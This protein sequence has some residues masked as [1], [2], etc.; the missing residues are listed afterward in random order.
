MVADVLLLV[1]HAQSSFSRAGRLAGHSDPPLSPAG[2]TEVAG[3]VRTDSFRQACA[4][5]SVVASSDLRRATD[6]AGPIAAALGRPVEIHVDLRERSFGAYDGQPAERARAEAADWPAVEQCC[7]ARPPGGESL[8]EVFRR[9][10]HGLAGVAGRTPTGTEALVVGHSMAWRLIAAAVSAEPVFPLTEPIRPTLT[11]W[12]IDVEA[13]LA[14]TRGTADPFHCS[15]AREGVNTVPCPLMT[16][17][18]DERSS[19]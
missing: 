18:D 5:V 8:G 1:R 16:R 2:E 17:A 4:A 14:A 3:W 9:V 6:T 10:A 7:T 13:L 19:G 15:L 11:M 12:R